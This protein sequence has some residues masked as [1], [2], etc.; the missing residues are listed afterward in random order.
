MDEV[1]Y[2]WADP[3]SPQQQVA[4]SSIAHAMN[5]KHVMAI[6][7]WVSRDGMDPKMGVLVPALFDKVECLL[8]T[9]VCLSS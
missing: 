2:I 3:S 6:A 8:W 9:H 5:K 7:R 4:L 1:Q